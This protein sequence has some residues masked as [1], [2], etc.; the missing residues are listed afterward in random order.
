MS[1]TVPG[2]PATRA[3]EVDP[4]TDP[5]WELLART[6]RGSLFTS[7]RWIRAVC[8]TYG[9]TPHAVVVRD[10]ADE[11]AG[12]LAWVPL[13][14]PRGE[15]LS[16]L[17]FSDHADPPCP[18]AGTWARVLD[19]S[20]AAAAGTAPF[21]LR[22]FSDSPAVGDPRL[23]TTGRVAWHG[24]RLDA[25]PGELAARLDPSARRAVAKAERSGV[26]VDLRGD[27]DAVRTF[28]GLHVRLRKDKYRMLAPP[29]E[30]F[31]RIWAEFAPPGHLTTALALLDGEPVAGA[32]FLQWNGTLYYKFGASRREHLAARP[33]DAVF[34]AGIRHGLDRGL[35]LLDWGISDLDQP[36]L[37]AFKRKWASHERSVLTL[38]A[39]AP[40]PGD[41]AFG[42]ALAELTR[43][44]TDASVPDPVTERAGALLYRWFC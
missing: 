21:V 6:G 1:R 26:V 4:R 22:C 37:V 27:L 23:R 24:T 13:D 42:T 14:D 9:F 28:H 25:S 12:G 30:F 41:T 40:D 32:L 19:A 11:P 16:S 8:G 18:D 38:R 29:L 5:A 15:R 3:A 17:P 44:L 36:G 43:L 20:G 39:G 31:E 35:V 10:A 34:W 2:P 33:N 7:P